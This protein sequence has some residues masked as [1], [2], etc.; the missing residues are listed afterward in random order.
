MFQCLTPI[1][2]LCYELGFVPEDEFQRILSEEEE[3]DNSPAKT[4]KP[5]NEMVTNRQRAMIINH[6]AYL[7]ELAARR[8]AAEEEESR[9][10][11]AKIAKEID[12]N[13]RKKQSDD[14]DIIDDELL[15]VKKPRRSLCSMC[16]N[17]K[18]INDD[19]WQKCGLKG[20]RS[21][22]CYRSACIRMCIEHRDICN[23]KV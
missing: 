16:K 9:K 12:N 18:E 13:K 2:E 4:G 15:A 14:Y 3:V 23:H 5:L 20:C 7:Q 19:P 21:Q 17:A 1:S 8:L 11:A 10:K 22:F 6:P